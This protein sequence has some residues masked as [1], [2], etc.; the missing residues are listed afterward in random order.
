MIVNMNA[1]FFKSTGR[2]LEKLSLLTCLFLL[3]LMVM[4]A[5]T[6]YISPPLVT[7]PPQVDANNFINSGTWSISTASP[8]MTAHTLNYT[9]NSGGSMRGSVG[10]EFDWGPAVSGPRRWSAN[11][12]NDNQAF[13]TAVDS[14]L[15]NPIVYPNLTPESYL[16]VSA[17]NIVNKGTL[18][19]GTAGEIILTGSNVNLTHSQMEIIPVIPIGSVNT[20]NN[21]TNYSPDTAIYDQYWGSNNNYTITG[22]VLTGGDVN[23]FTLLNVG[24][25]CGVFTNSIQIPRENR[26]TPEVRARSLP[27]VSFRDLCV[28]VPNRV[29][30]FE[31]L[32]EFTTY[33]TLR[34]CTK[35]SR[36][37]FPTTS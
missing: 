18:S 12:F 32:G 28:F 4:G 23:D 29:N 21:G 17:T 14:P 19:A 6:T 15:P 20:A 34:S 16:L 37:R 10:W 9:N 27:P 13:I 7:F 5:G 22:S 25:P 35:D 11:F 30:W 33:F 36:C 1:V 24:Q 2:F 26:K 3:P 8:F 31:A